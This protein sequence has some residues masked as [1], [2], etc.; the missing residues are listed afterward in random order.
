[1]ALG[2]CCWRCY[3]D[4][5]LEQKLDG[6]FAVDYV[7]W[8]RKTTTLHGLCGAFDSSFYILMAP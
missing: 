3:N 7:E 4:V 6:I 8:R 1:M 5:S 2:F